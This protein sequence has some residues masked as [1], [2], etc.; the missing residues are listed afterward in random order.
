VLQF[1]LGLWNRSPAAY[2]DATD[3][4]ALLLPSVRLLQYYKNSVDQ[5]PGKYNLSQLRIAL[6]YLLINII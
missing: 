3:T 4:G 5:R 2:A 6:M 1:A